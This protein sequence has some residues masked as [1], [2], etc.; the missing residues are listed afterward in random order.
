MTLT[1]I[2]KKCDANIVQIDY[3]RN[4][5]KLDFGEANVTIALETKGQAHQ[6]SITK[7]LL[8]N[9]YTFKKI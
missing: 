9:G 3:D 1:S 5:V 7:E 8:N 2:F 6:E 4:S